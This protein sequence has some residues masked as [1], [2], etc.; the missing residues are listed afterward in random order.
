MRRVYSDKRMRITDNLYK[1]RDKYLKD[2]EIET[3]KEEEDLEESE[4]E[5]SLGTFFQN[6]INGRSWIDAGSSGYTG[7]E[8]QKRDLAHIN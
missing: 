4:L 3:A 1:T 5:A 6:R 2:D 7:N 8:L